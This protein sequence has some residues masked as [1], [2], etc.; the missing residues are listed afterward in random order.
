MSFFPFILLKGILSP[1]CLETYHYDPKDITVLID[2]DDPNH[3]QPTREN[4]IRM[5]IE[6][7]EGAVAGDSFFFHCL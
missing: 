5:M 2:D 1:R 7:I 6:L 4:M 3:M